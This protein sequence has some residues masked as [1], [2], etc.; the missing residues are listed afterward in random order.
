MIYCI[1]FL[2]ACTNLAISGHLQLWHGEAV[3]IPTV[4][5]LTAAEGDWRHWL[6][7][8][9]AWGIIGYFTDLSFALL[10]LVTVTSVL[11]YY[12]FERW[13][14]RDNPLA[15]T[16]ALSVLLL[17]MLGVFSGIT[18]E[19]LSLAPLG[20]LV[21]SLPLIWLWYSWPRLREVV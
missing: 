2:F 11:V 7:W 19:R 4:L 13:I 3:L 15:R 21:I 1:V 18:L 9:A 12:I 14:D 17:L 20:S 10:L 6:I 8:Y 16:V 5:L